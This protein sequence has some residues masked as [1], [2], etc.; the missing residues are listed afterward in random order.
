MTGLEE[1]LFC[2]LNGF[3]KYSDTYHTYETK[4]KGVFISKYN[5]LKN[6]YVSCDEWFLFST[7]AFDGDCATKTILDDVLI[8]SIDL[9]VT[10]YINV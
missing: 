7:E 8:S 10:E 5:H 9:F 1:Y 6:H 4:Y 3:T 2:V